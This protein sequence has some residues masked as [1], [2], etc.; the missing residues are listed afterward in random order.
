MW[1]G[2]GVGAVYLAFGVEE[3]VCGAD[4]LVYTGGGLPVGLVARGVVVYLGGVVYPGGAVY[5][6]EGEGVTAG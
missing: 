5:L 1:A 2:A 3:E 6:G 4:G